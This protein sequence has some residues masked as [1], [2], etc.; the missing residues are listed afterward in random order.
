MN[1]EI[2][3]QFIPSAEQVIELYLSAGLRRPLEEP[4]RIQKMLD[5]ANLTLTAYD[6]D[7]LVG[8]ARSLTDFSYC[9]YLSDL[10]VR[11]EYQTQGIG[12]L[13]IQRTQE[14]LGDEVM[15]L[16]LSAPNAM[17]YYPH[18]G[19]TYVENAFMLPRKS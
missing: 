17:S 2:K 3:E 14:I 11:E 4:K 1:I 15:I 12:K 10:A 19:F 16:L 18:V 8:I 13:L 6:G 5:N 9:C 7:L